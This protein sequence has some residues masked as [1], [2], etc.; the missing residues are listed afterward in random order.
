[1]FKVNDGFRIA[2]L[3]RA[4]EFTDKMKVRILLRKR[5]KN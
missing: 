3:V 5:N 4:V 1:M 2:Q